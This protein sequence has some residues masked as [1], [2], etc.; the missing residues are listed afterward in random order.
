MLRD[1]LYFIAVLGIGLMLTLAHAAHAEEFDSTHKAAH[2]GS[3]FMLNT[4]LYGFSKKGLRLT[5]TD[6][7][8]FSA[9]TTLAIGAAYKGMERGGSKTFGDAMLYNGIGSASFGLTVLMFDF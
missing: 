3:A 9:F 6:A 7:F 1:M 5:S 8:I 4:A 2:M